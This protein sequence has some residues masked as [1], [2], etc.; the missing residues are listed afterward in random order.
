MRRSEQGWAGAVFWTRFVPFAEGAS[1]LFGGEFREERGG[2]HDQAHMPVPAMP[3]TGLAVIQ[4]E[5]VPG[6]GPGQAL[7]AQEAFLDGPARTASAGEFGQLD[8]GVGI[9]DIIR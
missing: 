2:G 6:S 8:A 5:I 1:A 9:G 4:T 3:G 7:R